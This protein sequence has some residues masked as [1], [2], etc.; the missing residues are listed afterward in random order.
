MISLRQP[1][2]NPEAV[3]AVLRVQVGERVHLR[4]V[5]LG[6]ESMASGGP[7]Q[8]HV[9]LGAEGRAEAVEVWWPDGGRD[10]VEQPEALGPGA[11][12]IWRATGG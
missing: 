6:G 8:V 7:A 11:L 2:P 9:G 12:R 3:G 4:R 10:R 1:G 5:H